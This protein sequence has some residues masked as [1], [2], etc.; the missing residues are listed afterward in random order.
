MK[1]G[2]RLVCSIPNSIALYGQRASSNERR[3]KTRIL[4]YKAH[5]NVSVSEPV[6]MKEGLRPLTE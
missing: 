4:L 1:E 2:L 3:I 6:P 5:K